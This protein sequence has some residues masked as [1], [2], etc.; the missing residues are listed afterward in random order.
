M[1]LSAE[2]TFKA[3]NRKGRLLGKRTERSVFHSLAATAVISCTHAEPRGGSPHRNPAPGLIWFA[4]QPLHSPGGTAQST[5]MIAQGF[6]N[7]SPWL[8]KI[9]PVCHH[10]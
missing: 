9:P 6:E 1:R 5:D 8:S 4:P 10:A 2:P 7:N 3:E